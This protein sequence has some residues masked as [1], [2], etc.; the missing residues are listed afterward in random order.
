MF[1]YFIPPHLTER[2]SERKRERVSVFS[3]VCQFCRSISA[4]PHTLKTYTICI[5]TLKGCDVRRRRICFA[6]SL[7]Q[8]THT[9]TYTHTHTTHIHAP[10]RA[11]TQTCTICTCVRHI[12]SLTHSATFVLCAFHSETHADRFMTVSIPRPPRL[13]CGVCT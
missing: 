12:H 4:Q 1:C 3:I 13:R 11:N 8:C 5:H 10:A 2:A 7:S 9:H 6:Q